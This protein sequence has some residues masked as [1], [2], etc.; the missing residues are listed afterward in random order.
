MD[1]DID[2]YNGVALTWPIKESL[3]KKRKMFDGLL[4]RNQ[5]VL[6]YGFA[7]FSTQATFNIGNLFLEL[8]DA[9]TES[10]RPPGF[11]ELEL[12]EYDFLLEEQSYPFADQAVSVHEENM[13]NAWKNQYTPWVDKSIQ[14][15]GKLLPTRYDKPIE[16]SEYNRVIY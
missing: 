14:S 13:K 7:E 5:E 2:A 4:K 1:E 10:E 3:A 8:S 9:L 16:L 6:N 11:S 12:E 15:L